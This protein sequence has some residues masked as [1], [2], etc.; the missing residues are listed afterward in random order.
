MASLIMNAPAPVLLGVGIGLVVVGIFIVIRPLSSL[1]LLAIFAGLSAIASGLID[2]VA[3]RTTPRWWDRAICG[4]WIAGGATILIFLGQSLELLPAALA[5]LLIIGGLGSLG[6]V[7]R[8]RVS[9]RVLSG[10]WGIAQLVFGFLALLWP[11]ITLLVVAVLFGLR[12][13][14]FGVALLARVTRKMAGRPEQERPSANKKHGW[15]DAGRYVLAVAVLM[16]AASTL[17]LNAWLAGGAPVVDA[18]Y[19]PPESVPLTAGELI[20]DDTFIGTAPPGGDVRR[21]LYTTTDTYGRDAVASALVITPKDPPAGHMP[22]ILWNHGTTGVARGCAPSLTDAAATKWAIPALDDVLDKGWA[23]VAPDYSGQGAPGVFPY[24]IGQGE[25]RS[26]L[27]G[28]R[29]AQGLDGLYFS[30]IVIT[31]GHSQ[32]GHAALWEAQIAADYAPELDVRGVAAL[33][34]AADPLALAEELTTSDASGLL[35]I[36]VSWVLVPYSDTYPDVNIDDYVAPAGQ[37]LVRE[38]TQRCLSEPGV[39]VSAITSLGV[40]AD[41]PLFPV[42]LT[43]GTLGERLEANAA[44][45]PFDVPVLVAWGSR[46]EVIPPSLQKKYVAE[47][48]EGESEV[49]LE[50]VVYQAA[51]HR[52]VLVPRSPFLPTLMA[53]TQN[54]LAQREPRAN[55]CAA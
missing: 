7:R 35:S 28:V 51:N 9:V 17:G 50:W 3:P 32:G 52:G 55:D 49:Q 12:T 26:G 8:G 13:I 21:I 22:V 23:V 24:L 27:D 14:I 42:D 34:P 18:F 54:T 1:L 20:R 5:L 53:W 48:C 44:K 43:T 38:M 45:G 36:M 6:G 41:R 19:D 40:T 4:V 29:A 11:D 15:A 39:V 47:L 33:A 16:L 10:A 37:S 46:D 25:A 2:L 31:W 30:N